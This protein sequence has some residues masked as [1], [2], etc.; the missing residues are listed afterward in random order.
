[1]SGFTPTSNEVR[2]GLSSSHY[3]TLAGQGA[4][5]AAA[6]EDALCQFQSA[7][8]HEDALER[9]RGHRR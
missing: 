1:M 6:Y 3:L 9:G 7:L 2:G 8:V 4:L 5:E